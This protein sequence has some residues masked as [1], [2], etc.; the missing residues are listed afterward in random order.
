[1]KPNNFWE[2]DQLRKLAT[3]A[4]VDVAIARLRSTIIPQPS[5]RRLVFL[6]RLKEHR[7]TDGLP[8]VNIHS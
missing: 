6:A 5:T 4:Q 1:M 3:V 8:P 2:A 7:A